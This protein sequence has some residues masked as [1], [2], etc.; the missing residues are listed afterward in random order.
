MYVV[1]FVCTCTRVHHWGSLQFDLQVIL[2]SVLVQYI[3]V[4]GERFPNLRQ[5][6]CK[7]F[8]RRAK[9]YWSIQRN[10]SCKELNRVLRGPFAWLCQAGKS[11]LIA[12]TAH[13]SEVKREEGADSCTNFSEA[14]FIF[15]RQQRAYGVESDCTGIWKRCVVAFRLEPLFFAGPLCNKNE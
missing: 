2:Y 8:T 13:I 1:I 4:G 5:E 10:E 3:K 11:S 14:C 7:M 9:V 15:V 12:R 6:V